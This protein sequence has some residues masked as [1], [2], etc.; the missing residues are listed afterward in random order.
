MTPRGDAC[1]AA[2]DALP[3]SRSRERIEGEGPYAASD[4]FRSRFKI[5][6]GA[7]VTQDLLA[8]T[9]LHYLGVL[10]EQKRNLESRAK[11]AR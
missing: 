8:Q 7:G 1:I 3:L 11:K 2:R 5:V 10:S 9:D 4:S 6:T